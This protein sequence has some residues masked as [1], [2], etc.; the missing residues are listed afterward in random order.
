MD[1]LRLGVVGTG[2]VVREIYQYLYYRSSYSSELRVGAICDADA[3]ARDAFGDAWKI[4]GDRRFADFRVMMRTVELD[5]VAVNTPDSLHREPAIAALESGLDVVLPKPTAATVADAHAI[6]RA[7]RS[8]HRS[9]GVDFH[10]REDPVTKEARARIAEGRYGKL[11]SSVWYMLDKLQVSD[12][13][14]VPRFFSSPDFAGRNSPVTFLTSHMA[15]TFMHLTR[16]R[17]VEVRAVGYRQKLPSL[18][19]LAVQGYDLVDTTVVFEGGVL[20]HIITGWALPN[21]ANS[22]TVQSARLLFSDGMLELWRDHYGYHEVTKD[23]IDDRNILFRNFEESGVVSGFGIDSPGRIIRS[24]LRFRAGQMS[25][26]EYE[27]A[28]SPWAMGVYT[29]LVCECAEVSLERGTATGSGAV[30]G[31]TVDARKHLGERIGGEAV[32]YYA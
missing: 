23:G 9:V 31:A 32:P 14:H 12:P 28:L 29:S 15:D 22:L 19:P 18:R 3:K 7:A 24:I 11:Q 16:L 2:S 13:N 4:P 21:T 25:A 10:K 5:A 8:A 6:A 17:P 27:A 30:L 1:A 26:S 20:C